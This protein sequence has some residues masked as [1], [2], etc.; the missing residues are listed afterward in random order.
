[1]KKNG[2]FEL[3][4]DEYLAVLPVIR[5]LERT[6]LG[7]ADGAVVNDRRGFLWSIDD[8]FMEVIGQA[9]GMPDRYLGGIG[10]LDWFMDE[11][12][13]LWWFD[14]GERY[15]AYFLV[16]LNA[17]E[18]SAD[19][20]ETRQRYLELLNYLV[21]YWTQDVVKYKSEGVTRDFTVYLVDGPGEPRPEREPWFRRVAA[22]VLGSG[23][24]P[25]P[26]PPVPAGPGPVVVDLGEGGTTVEDDVVF[27]LEEPPGGGLA[28][29]S[30]AGD[31]A[32]GA[33][34][35]DGR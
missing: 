32:G 3:T 22:R 7:E 28:G 8:R 19:N 4:N 16:V 6:W 24:K 13:D 10:H 15:D 9:M 1:M 23:E 31:G 27:W 26:G 35:E 11:I 14:A 33:G 17:A 2:V 5:G 29:P 30:V 21:R 25:V 18:M 34:G 12:C 20:S